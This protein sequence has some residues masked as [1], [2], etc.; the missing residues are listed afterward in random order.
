MT[1][2]FRCKSGPYGPGVPC[3]GGR[4]ER[5]GGGMDGGSTVLVRAVV[6]TFPAADGAPGVRLEGFGGT[7]LDAPPASG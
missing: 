5:E 4:G 6:G 7:G 3:G 1:S 2:L